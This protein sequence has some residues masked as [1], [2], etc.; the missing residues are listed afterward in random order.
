MCEKL[1]PFC[2]HPHNR[3]TYLL[4][5]QYCD[6]SKEFE[7]EFGTHDFLLEGDRIGPSCRC[8][9]NLPAFQQKSF[10]KRQVADCKHDRITNN[11]SAATTSDHNHTECTC[12]RA[13][14]IPWDILG[15]HFNIFQQKHAECVPGDCGPC[16]ECRPATLKESS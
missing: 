13:V 9:C 1:D 2:R 8:S 11:L 5:S 16:Q 15:C 4:Q 10:A 6:W 12:K 14:L 3:T 7:A